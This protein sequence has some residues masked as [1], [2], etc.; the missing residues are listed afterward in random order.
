M[1]TLFQFEF[2]LLTGLSQ[3]PTPTSPPQ[4]ASRCRPGSDIDVTRYEIADLGNTHLVAFNKFS[5]ARPHLSVL[6]E[7]GFTRQHEPLNLADINALHTVLTSLQKNSKRRY[8]A[9]FNCGIDSGCSRLHKHMQV[10]PAGPD[11]VE[12]AGTA[13]NDFSAVARRG[14]PCCRP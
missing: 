3:K 10:F 8:L 2:R 9:I 12:T 7:D 5:S 13:V 11:P 4:P 1:L 14:G 6:T